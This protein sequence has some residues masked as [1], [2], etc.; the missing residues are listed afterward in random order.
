MAVRKIS[1]FE[2]VLSLKD[3]DR[4]LLERNGEPK[5]IKAS[6]LLSYFNIE[7]PTF[8][9]VINITGD[10]V[11]NTG[12][13]NIFAYDKCEGIYNWVS[14]RDFENITITYKGNIYKYTTKVAGEYLGLFITEFSEEGYIQIYGQTANASIFDF[15]LMIMSDNVISDSFPEEVKDKDNVVL[16]CGDIFGILNTDLP[17]TFN[18]ENNRVV[19][20]PIF[21][22]VDNKVDITF[23]KNSVIAW[24]NMPNEH[25]TDKNEKNGYLRVNVPGLYDWIDYNSYGELSRLKLT[26][27]NKTY[28]FCQNA[29]YSNSI[30][31]GSA[32]TMYPNDTDDS[33]LL[34]CQDH[35]SVPDTVIYMALAPSSDL[36]DSMGLLFHKDDF[37]L[38]VIDGALYD[39]D[40]LPINISFER[41]TGNENPTEN[42]I[43]DN[44]VNLTFTSDNIKTIESA[45]MAA[46]HLDGISDWLSRKRLSQAV[47]SLEGYDCVQVSSSSTTVPYSGFIYESSESGDMSAL[48]LVVYTSGY[49]RAAITIPTADSTSYGVNK[50]DILLDLSD[51]WA[52]DFNI[53]DLPLHIKIFCDFDINTEDDYVEDNE[54]NLNFKSEDIKS[55]ESDGITF[56]YCL[57]NLPGITDWLSNKALSDISLYINNV[58]YEFSDNI[59]SNPDSYTYEIEDTVIN[60]KE[61]FSII[62]DPYLS[63]YSVSSS[64]YVNGYPG[65]T[66]EAIPVIPASIYGYPYKVMANIYKEPQ[67]SDGMLPAVLK[68]DIILFIDYYYTSLLPKDLPL[69]IRFEFNDNTVINSNKIDVTFNTENFI[70]S[71]ESVSGGNYGVALKN[72]PG[73]SDWFKNKNLN[74]VKAKIN[75]VIYQYLP[76][77]SAYGD[78]VDTKM[79]SSGNE[80]ESAD[81]NAIIVTQ[82]IFYNKESSTS[83]YLGYIYPEDSATLTEYSPKKDDFLIAIG[84]MSSFKEEDLPVNLEFI[85]KEPTL[86]VAD[87]IKEREIDIGFREITISE[88]SG[89]INATHKNIA[90]ISDWFQSKSLSDIVISVNGLEY[91]YSSSSSDVK[92]YQY[93]GEVDTE[94]GINSFALYIPPSEPSTGLRELHIYIINQNIDSPDTPEFGIKDNIIIA[95]DGS[96]GYKTDD[97]LPVNIKFI[98]TGE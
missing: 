34:T 31:S 75:G 63:R 41:I 30:S 24:A 10:Q 93:I 79:W 81:N 38:S 96:A 71:G 86:P 65:S 44:E 54:I 69:N 9:G 55:V 62:Y 74:Y 49:P 77:D 18:V 5:F 33:L 59:D 97:I 57:K 37:A 64:D 35:N 14:S 52:Q 20:A 60:K 73:C 27:N 68:D 47:V 82:I 42:S 56:Y 28:N 66:D 6:N 92:M 51:S 32:F 45:Q 98:Y 22:I 85:Y 87:S 25:W 61:Y 88:S 4:I 2:E 29:I 40:S 72:I 17:V 78:V 94:S 80:K 23:D 15:T 43:T 21:N 50:D 89:E 16:Y 90:G 19:S 84:S 83:I 7:T 8:S 46:L 76:N 26:A 48:A 67:D 95:G 58:K 53:D 91:K 12:G 36:T 1:E 11:L 13:D 3:N 70:N 39:M